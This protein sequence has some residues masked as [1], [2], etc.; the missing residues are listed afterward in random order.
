MVRILW[1]LAGLVWVPCKTVTHTFEFLECCVKAG[2]SCPCITHIGPAFRCQKDRDIGTVCTAKALI[3]GLSCK[4]QQ[5]QFSFFK[6]IS[7][8]VV[9]SSPSASLGGI[10][11][12]CGTHPR[13]NLLHRS[14]SCQW[15]PRLCDPA[16]ALLLSSSFCPRC[17]SSILYEL[18]PPWYL[19]AYFSIFGSCQ[20][21]P[22]PWKWA[23]ESL[24]LILFWCF[25]LSHKMSCLFNEH[26]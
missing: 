2:T 17:L 24:L 8:G 5:D 18:R 4:M 14:G 10:L 11:T 22:S 12:A 21:F 16:L 23:L 26:Y 3:I 13:E 25:L 19:Q 15:H 6:Y 20:T 1:R 7:N 9:L